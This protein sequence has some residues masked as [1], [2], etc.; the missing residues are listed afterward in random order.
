M[1]HDQS[2]ADL[3]YLSIAEASRRI[4]DGALAPTALTDAVFER[5]AITDGALN[6]Y[7]RLM[8]ESARAEAEAADERAR[9]GRRL[10]P[11]DG[12]P[13]GVKD[14]YDTAGVVTTGGTGAYR[15]RVP[16][17]DAT[18][19]RRLREAG[20]IILGKTN[21]HELALGGTTNNAHFGATHNPWHLDRVPG[22]SS[23]GSGAA[24]AG[25]QALGALGTDTGGSIRIPAAF[26]G[27]TGHKPTYGLVGRG[28]VIPLSLTLDH[29]G[30]MARSVE[31]CALM[32]N[33]LAGPDP[34]DHGSAMKPRAERDQETGSDGDYT[35]GLDGGIAGLRL[36]VVPSLVEGCTD[37]VLAA[38]ERS[39]DVLRGLGATI[40]RAEPMAG[41]DTWRSQTASII[42]V[43]GASYIEPILR[44]T[45]LAIGELVRTRMSRG[46]EIPAT[47]YARAL[48]AR[49]DIEARYERALAEGGFDAYVL[50]TS[51]ITAEPIGEDAHT[52]AEPALKFR[53]TSVF[54]NTHQPSVSVPNG[55]DHDGMP[56]G[57]MVST[58][59]FQDG[60]ALRIAHAYQQ[61]TDFHTRRP[62]F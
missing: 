19:V 3:A 16:L 10:G 35:A 2:A 48:E 49:K 15:E 17:E 57:L 27:I 33:V 26:C 47:V 4:A 22:G 58:A 30:P 40:E 54:D 37:D 34:R 61:A 39:L 50:P 41:L 23:G 56:T 11:L 12:I 38:F 5:I 46:L 43:E 25:G 36:A 59:L 45:P 28:G 51:P 6:S 14:L 7:V 9:A 20:A 1:P 55:F 60:L 29:A 8:T 44:G 42:V 13:I 18:A 24:L 52:E 21:T 53:N 62:E 32:L 31:D